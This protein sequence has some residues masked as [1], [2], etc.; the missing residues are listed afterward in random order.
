MQ[1]NKRRH[2]EKKLSSSREEYLKAIYKLS[3]RTQS[4]RSIDIALY[5]GVSKPS[6]HNA[7]TTLQEEGLVIKPFGGE[8]QLTEEG[9]KQGEAITTKFQIIRQFLITCC[10][11]DE[12][13]A[14]A[15]ACKMEHIISD[16]TVFALKNILVKGEVLYE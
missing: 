2:S 7:V 14:N 5:L 1:Q 10:N 15:D 16:E 3:K 12:L 6:V 4:V 11:V 8:I 9:R 13:T